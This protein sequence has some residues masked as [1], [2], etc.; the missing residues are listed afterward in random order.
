MYLN[1]LIF[2]VYMLNGEE[3][4]CAFDTLIVI[5]IKYNNLVRFKNENR[6]W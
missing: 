3:I 1:K 4:A 5:S 6:G 2:N